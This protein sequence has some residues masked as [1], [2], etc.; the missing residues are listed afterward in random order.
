MRTTH[1]TY[2]V[3]A[4]LLLATVVTAQQS[5]QKSD[6]PDIVVID[7]SWDKQFV[8]P[9]FNSN[10]LEPNEELIR[11]TR[12]EKAVIRQRDYSLPNQTTE[13]PMP[14]PAGRPVPVGGR[15]IYLYRV[16]VKNTGAKQIKAI[17]WEFQFLHPETNEVL[18]SRRIT[19]RVKLS[20]GKTRKL[21][22][23]LPQQPTR[24]VSADELDKKYRDQFKEQVVIHRIDYSDGTVWEREP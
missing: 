18:G 4:T 12:A 7:K 5:A 19:S 13:I 17:D 22:A 16:T 15:S 9:D 10:P 2:S 14:L 23:Y 3:L 1:L 24:V 6:P 11:Q 21:K 8:R 20:A